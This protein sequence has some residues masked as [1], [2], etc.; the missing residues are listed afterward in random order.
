MTTTSSVLTTTSAPAA[1]AAMAPI[2]DPHPPPST[3]DTFN[4][5]AGPDVAISRGS[6]VVRAYAVFEVDPATHKVRVKVVDD[7]GRLIRLIPSESV[8]AMLATMTNAAGYLG[9]FR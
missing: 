3:M 9:R 5:L 4:K 8:A 6:S 1:A 2:Q 7:T